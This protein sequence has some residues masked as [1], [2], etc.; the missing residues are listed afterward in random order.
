M[1]TGI[2]AAEVALILDRKKMEDLRL[3]REEHRPKKLNQHS[4]KGMNNAEKR[5]VI[6]YQ[7]AW[8]KQDQDH[9]GVVALRDSENKGA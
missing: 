9:P 8:D 4:L 5:L 3:A 2:V 1:I 7:T 6:V